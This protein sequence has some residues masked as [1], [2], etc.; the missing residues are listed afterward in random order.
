MRNK[1]VNKRFGKYSLTENLLSGGGMGLLTEMQL[2]AADIQDLADDLLKVP[3]SGKTPDKKRQDAGNA[4]EAFIIRHLGGTNT[5]TIERNFPMVDVYVG[6]LN[7]LANSGGNGGT[8]GLI[9]YSV[10]ASSQTGKHGVQQEL[11]ANTMANKLDQ[12]EYFLPDQ[13]ECKIRFGVY[14]LTIDYDN[15]SVQVHK[16]DLHTI[17]LKK[18]PDGKWLAVDAHEQTSKLDLSKTAPHPHFNGGNNLRTPDNFAAVGLELSQVGV[19]AFNK[20]IDTTGDGNLDTQ[21]MDPAVHDSNKEYIRKGENARNRRSGFKGSPSQF[22]GR[23]NDP[24][25]V[26]V[27]S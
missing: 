16:S 1:R 6:D 27:P 12:Y 20:H 18:Q 7:D 5:D 17:L 11:N 26:E 23:G 13:T 10:K 2:T 21:I 14:V 22:P 8:G 25:N 24:T 15:D 3:G 9:F 19:G 4:G